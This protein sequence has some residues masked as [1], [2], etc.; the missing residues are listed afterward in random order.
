MKIKHILD[1]I[2]E[3]QLFIPAF[4]R[5]YVWKRNDAKNLMMSLVQE[6]PTGTML[7]WETMNP[8]ELKGDWVY[9]EKQG[10]VKLILDGQQRI[11]TLYMLI[12][13]EYPPYYTKAEIL[14]DTRNLYMHLETKEFQYYKQKFMENNPLWI[15]ITD[16]FQGKIKGYQLGSRFSDQIYHDKMDVIGE[17]FNSLQQVP[18]IDFLEQQI[19]VKASLKEAIDIFY[20]VNAS[21]V[22]LTDAELA[23]AQIS[24]YWPQAR[25]KFKAKLSTLKENGF[26]FKLD[27]IIYALLGVLYHQG[28]N[29]KKLHG[30]ENLEKIKEAWKLLDENVIDHVLN[31]LQ[32]HAHVNHSKEINSVYALIPIIVYTY[33]KHANKESFTEEEINKI[34]KWYYYSQI[35]QRYIS[36]LPQKL[37][38]DNSIAATSAQPFDELLNIIKAERSLEISPD[39]FVGTDIRNALYSLMTCYFKSRGA[40]CFNTG[41]GIEQNMGKKYSLEWDHIF[42]CS[43]LKKNGYN[44]NNRIKYSL[45][46]EITNRAIITQ[47]ANRTKT[48]KEAYGYLKE[49]KK[50]YPKALE[51]QLIPMDEELWKMENYEKFLQKRRELLAKHLN[52]YLN[53]FSDTKDYIGEAGIDQLIKEGESLELELKASYQW[54]YDKQKKDDEYEYAIFRTIAA[55]AN[56]KGGTL[57][58]GVNDESDVKGLAQDISYI[59]GDVDEFN[60]YLQKRLNSV[61]DEAFI[62]ENLTIEFIEFKD[63]V[64]CKIEIKGAKSPVFISRIYDKVRQ[65]FYI[66]S[67]ASSIEVNA[68]DQIQFIKDN[69]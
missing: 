47:L 13:G 17:N 30:R 28:K 43:L 19:P 57:I 25:E 16:V 50:N 68:K 65:A 45:A 41:V 51:L 46:Q 38:K 18:D 2:D 1:K 66:R 63:D 20:I 35:R 10:A 48:N 32:T 52:E 49:V 33:K 5:E 24:G 11:T 60:E 61:F 26:D 37:D 21:G 4:Q 55:F 27:F 3:K 8:P 31:I 6:Y 40:V 12:R 15:N 56:T 9:S 36:Q 34:V 69:F 14:N 42:P 64:I 39:E 29:M 59:E 58:L 54:N 67:G 22:N 53:S 7:T 23:L 44:R 62:N